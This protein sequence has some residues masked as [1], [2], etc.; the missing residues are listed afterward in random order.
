MK[1]PSRHELHHIYGLSKET[2]ITK[3]GAANPE[4]ITFIEENTGKYKVEAWPAKPDKHDEKI[5][6]TYGFDLWPCITRTGSNPAD[7]DW[8][9]GFVKFACYDNRDVKAAIAKKL[10]ALP[11]MAWINKWFID[12]LAFE[13]WFAHLHRD[14]IHTKAQINIILQNNAGHS[15]LSVDHKNKEHLVTP[16]A[17][18]LVFLDIT[19]PHA[20]I[21]DQS[22][23]IDYMKENPMRALAVTIR[24]QGE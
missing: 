13:S 15:L 3:V 6:K 8:D 17:G 14:E 10:S 20:L 1:K 22:M 7:K 23:G 12:L 19:Q 18:D 24:Y 2:T 11:E 4:I 16:M 21:P 5:A 9:G